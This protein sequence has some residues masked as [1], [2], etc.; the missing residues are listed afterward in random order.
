[1]LVADGA[2]WAS[3]EM[4]GD[5]SLDAS[6]NLSISTNS[7]TTEMLA[8]YAVTTM[9]LADSAVTAEKVADN[10][11]TTTKVAENAIT[12]TKVAENAITT[13]KVLKDAIDGTKIS[14]DSEVVGD[15]LVFDGTD[16]VR[17]EIG[18]GGQTLQVDPATNLPVWDESIGAK[19]ASFL[20]GNVMWT[21]KA[22]VADTFGIALNGQ[23]VADGA[24]LYPELAAMITSGELQGVATLTGTDITMADWNEVGQ[25]DGGYF[26]RGLGNRTPGS[27]ANHKTARPNTAFSLSG[28]AATAGAHTH[29]VTDQYRADNLKPNTAIQL[30]G[31]ASFFYPAQADMIAVSRTTSSSGGHTHSVTGTVNGGGDSETAPKA[32]SGLWYVFAQKIS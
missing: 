9:K 12:T 6:G 16:W 15:L 30:D 28:T 22:T 21:P 32:A 20:T 5:A 24:T 10:A 19:M 3:V 1:M 2:A 14:V 23:V 13:T 25:A 27:L 17:S 18:I 11:I 8:D 31:G 4:T 7:I 26:L 29:T